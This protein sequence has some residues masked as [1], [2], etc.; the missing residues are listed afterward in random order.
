MT[1]K[2]F[3]DTPDESVTLCCESVGRPD[4][5][6]WTEGRTYTGRVTGSGC[7]LIEVR[8]DL[9]YL[10]ML[11]NIERPTFPMGTSGPLGFERVWSAVFSRVPPEPAELE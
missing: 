3:S 7:G 2:P 8:D 1:W 11:L 9:G 5:S 6:M 4:T 10:R